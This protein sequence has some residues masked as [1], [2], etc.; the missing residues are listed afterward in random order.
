MAWYGCMDVGYVCEARRGMY[1]LFTGSRCRGR[2]KQA[3][4]A[5]G[6]SAWMKGVMRDCVSLVALTWVVGWIGG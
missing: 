4:M 1:I 3:S 2:W 5:V 6:G